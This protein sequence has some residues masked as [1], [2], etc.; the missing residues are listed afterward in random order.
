MRIASGPSG[1]AALCL[2]IRHASLFE[3]TVGLDNMASVKPMPPAARRAAV[4]TFARIMCE[5]YPGLVVV[6]LG[7]VGADG[8]VVAATPGKVIRP[9]AAPKNCNSI[10]DRDSGVTALDNHRV[11]GACENTLANVDR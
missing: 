9:F 11:D 2:T 1:T 4:Q 6:P 3:A 5:R 10:L 7:D 8:A